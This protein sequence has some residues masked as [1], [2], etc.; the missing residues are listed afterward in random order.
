MRLKDSDATLQ[1]QPDNEANYGDEV[2]PG[3]ISYLLVVI[4]PVQHHQD[5]MT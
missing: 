5:S 3:Q 4:L 2:R 1:P